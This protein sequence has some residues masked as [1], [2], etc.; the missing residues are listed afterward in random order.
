MKWLGY[1]FLEKKKTLAKS[2]KI[3]VIKKDASEAILAGHIWELKDETLQNV[4]FLKY[5]LFHWRFWIHSRL[6]H[7]FTAV[8]TLVKQL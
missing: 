1:T 6:K 5:T 7:T 3:A 2:D 4:S 8:C